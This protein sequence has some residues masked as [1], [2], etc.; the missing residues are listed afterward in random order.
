MMRIGIPKETK[1][2][3]GRVALVPAAAADLVKSGHEGLSVGSLQKALDIPNSTLSHHIT[4]LVSV[5]LV[6]QK[7]DGRILMCIPQ[8]QTFNQLLFFLNDECCIDEPI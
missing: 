4:K 3:E 7:R 5:K 6:E 8:Y 1:V 2:L